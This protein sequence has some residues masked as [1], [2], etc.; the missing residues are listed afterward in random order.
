MYIDSN[1]LNHYMDQSVFRS[2]NNLYK[3][4]VM[5]LHLFEVQMPCMKSNDNEQ[6]LFYVYILLFFRF[7]HSL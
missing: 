4:F 2:H 7:K 6:S 1:A 5:G 3:G